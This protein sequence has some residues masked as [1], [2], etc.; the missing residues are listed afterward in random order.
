MQLNQLTITDAAKGLRTGEFSSEELTNACLAA[1]QEQDH[2]IHAFLKISDRA[3]DAAKE[4]DRLFKDNPDAASPLTGIPLAMKDNILVEGEYCTAGSRMLENYIASYDATVIRKLKNQNAILLGKT[5]MDDSAMGSSTESSAFGPTKNPHD[6]TRVPGGSS[7]G[8]AAAVAAHMCL[9]ALGSDTGGSIRQPASFCGIVGMKPTYGAVSRHGLIAMASSLDQIGPMAK[10]V[11][12]AELLFHAIKGQD[13]FDATVAGQDSFSDEPIPTKLRIG[14]PKEYFSD[15]L[16]QDIKDAITKI[17]AAC[18]Q[19]GAELHEVSLPHSSYALPAYYIIVPSEVSSNLA[20]LDGIRYGYHHEQS[21][22][23]FDVYAQ[24]RARGFGPEIK[25]RIMLGTYA[26]SAGYYDAYY[27]KAQQVRRLISKDFSDAFAKVDVL[28]GP[29]TPTPAFMC[30]EKKDDPLKMYL[31]D[32]YT[33]AVN[34]AGLPGISIPAGFV[35]RGNAKLP[36]GLQLIAPRFHENQL[37]TVGK[38]IETL[39]P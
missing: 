31:A 6:L 24:S 39:Q 30:G 37:F 22:T 7:G 27:T 25:R 28:I 19:Q 8:S 29:T 38:M 33:V 16:D 21:M 12:D 32:I 14:V 9:G 18:E 35:M 36:V 4:A 23:L 2:D 5:N 34:L 13:G 10:T 15:G 1:I 26:L 17:L 3:A 20:R 11:A